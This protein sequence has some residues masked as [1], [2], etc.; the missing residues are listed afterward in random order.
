MTDPQTQTAVPAGTRNDGN[1]SEKHSG[2]FKENSYHAGASAATCACEAF[3]EKIDAAV[4]SLTEDV[5]E[6]ISMF[7]MNMVGLAADEYAGEVDALI[8]ELGEQITDAIRQA[9]SG[10]AL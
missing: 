3:V 9:R 1:A 8:E 7:A 10:V 4:D 2:A 6:A 5:S